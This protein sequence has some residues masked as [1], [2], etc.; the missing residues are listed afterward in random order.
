MSLHV[1]VAFAS[2]NDL[3]CV[4]STPTITRGSDFKIAPSKMGDLHKWIFEYKKHEV[5]V[6]ITLEENLGAKAVIEFALSPW[7]G[8]FRHGRGVVG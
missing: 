3:S 5:I 4:I 7:S 6:E 2:D 8:L 1:S